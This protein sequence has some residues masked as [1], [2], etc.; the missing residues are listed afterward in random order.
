MGELWVKKAQTQ[1]KSVL[2]VMQF[3]P[4]LAPFAF[5]NGFWVGFL[6]LVLLGLFVRPGGPK[7]QERYNVKVSRAEVKDS[8]VKDSG[9]GLT[10][11][12]LT[13]KVVNVAKGKQNLER[14]QAG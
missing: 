4:T 3:M 8:S 10:I 13:M 6:L 12:P 2:E 9:T 1:A 14:V 11:D 7:T 5:A